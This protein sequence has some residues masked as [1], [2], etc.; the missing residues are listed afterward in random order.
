VRWDEEHM[1]YQMDK[2]NGQGC[3]LSSY[4]IVRLWLLRFAEPSFFF[5]RTHLYFS[6]TGPDLKRISVLFRCFSTLFCFSHHLLRRHLD[7][8]KSGLPILRQLC[9]PLYHSSLVGCDKFQ[10]TVRGFSNT[11][12]STAATVHNG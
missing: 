8:A 1:D 11:Y 2:S 10:L 7:H 6:S 9:G 4:V 5:D 3:A 12:N